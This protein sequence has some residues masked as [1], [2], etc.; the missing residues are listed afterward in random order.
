MLSRGVHP[1]RFSNIEQLRIYAAITG[2]VLVL[3]WFALTFLHRGNPDLVAMLAT[4]VVGFELF[5]FGQD[6][7]LKWV[8]RNG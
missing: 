4:G 5:F 1:V 3:A 7:R 6:L 8:R 2:I